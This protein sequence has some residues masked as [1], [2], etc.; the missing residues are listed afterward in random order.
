MHSFRMHFQPYGRLTQD[1]ACALYIRTM[2]AA[3]ARASSRKPSKKGR[4]G[5]GSSSPGWISR[6]ALSRFFRVYI[7]I[8]GTGY[9]YLYIRYKEE[10]FTLS[11][12]STTYPLCYLYGLLQ[13]FGQ[14]RDRLLSLSILA[15]IAIFFLNYFCAAC[16]FFLYWGTDLTC[17]LLFAFGTHWSM[18]KLTDSCVPCRGV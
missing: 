1:A 8:P 10:G 13:R 6:L 18:K 9:T 3:R 2:Q 16:F 12:S 11:L 4:P 15:C 5:A 17:A 7:I 14:F